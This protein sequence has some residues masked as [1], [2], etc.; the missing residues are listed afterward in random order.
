M[1]GSRMLC[2]ERSGARDALVRCIA[3]TLRLGRPVR[4]ARV[5]M[6]SGICL[7]RSVRSCVTVE[8]SRQKSG[9]AAAPFLGDLAVRMASNPLGTKPSM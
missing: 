9:D 4:G 7:S 2:G 8:G 3:I 6:G 5:R 1:V